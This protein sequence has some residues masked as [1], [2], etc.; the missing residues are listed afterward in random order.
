[1]EGPRRIGFPDSGVCTP[2]L[3]MHWNLLRFFLSLSANRDATP[4][5]MP[6]R[7]MEPCSY[8][9]ALCVCTLCK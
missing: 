2:L 8:I 3:H 6:V 1:M 5:R 4:D 9:L 7:S